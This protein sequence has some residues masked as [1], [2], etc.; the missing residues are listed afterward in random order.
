MFWKLDGARRHLFAVIALATIFSVVLYVH[1]YMT[2]RNA[3]ETVDWD[4]SQQ[5]PEYLFA[6]EVSD[7]GVSHVSLGK[8][9]LRISFPA[10]RVFDKLIDYAQM[11]R[12]EVIDHYRFIMYVKLPIKTA[13][14]AY[15]EAIELARYFAIDTGELESWYK[16]VR[17]TDGYRA[18]IE[19]AGDATSPRY[20]I[21]CNHSYDEKLPWRVMF[22]GSWATPMPAKDS[23]NA[24]AK[25]SIAH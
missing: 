13:N 25:S 17:D 21:S 4:F 10:G 20:A 5:A 12:Y 14:D 16:E 22:Q 18:N 19:V 9:R 6:G 11:S 1:A 7:N 3:I 15:D 8:C 2:N 23:E 24:N